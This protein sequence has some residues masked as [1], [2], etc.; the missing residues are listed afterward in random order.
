MVLYID[1]N[2]NANSDMTTYSII[3]G[4]AIIKYVTDEVDEAMEFIYRT[5][6]NLDVDKV[7]I[8]TTSDMGVIIAIGLEIRGLNVKKAETCRQGVTT[9]KTKLSNASEPNKRIILSRG[10]LFEIVATISSDTNK[11][12][13]GVCLS[14][15]GDISFKDVDGTYYQLST[16]DVDTITVKDL[17]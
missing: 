17:K 3:G 8:D 6:D 12:L 9:N 5:V 1:F 11:K 16:K 2:K 14:G 13:R 15:G 10:N 7:Y 4:G